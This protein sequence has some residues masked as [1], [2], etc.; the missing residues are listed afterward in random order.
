MITVAGEA[1][2]DVVVGAGGALTALPGGAPYN[3][4]RIAAQLGGEVRFLG[5]LS[6]DA[7]GEQLH[8]ALA[9]EGVSLAVAEPTAEPTTLAIAQV[10]GDGIARYTF[11]L[12][13][14]SAAQLRAGDVPAGLLDGGGTLVVGGLGL[15][16]DPTASTLI[17]LIDRRPPGL[18]TILDPNCRP[19]AIS[20]LD[21][22]RARIAAVTERVQ[23][24]K[25][26]VEDLELLAPGV[27]PLDAARALL[28][29]GPRAVLLTDGPRPVTIL[30]PG[31]AH[32]VPVPRVDVVD[33]IG[34]G[35]AFVAG[36]LTAWTQRGAALSDEAL[37]A[38]AAAAVEVSAAVCTVQGARLPPGFR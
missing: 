15:A 34:A 6:E 24:V 32:T 14:T 13:G 26:S 1:L 25:V 23:L 2:I 18:T 29:R 38:A 7:F 17:G 22:Y 36:F 12:A 35:D 3:V 37:A 27:A 8:A 5:R 10:D 30:T 11:Y 19:A 16:V 28:A 9:R 20:D 4:A 21:A 33:T 31:R